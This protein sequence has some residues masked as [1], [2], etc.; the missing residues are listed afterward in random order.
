MLFSVSGLRCSFADEVP[1]KGDRHLVAVL[2][3]R[4]DGDAEM[5]KYVSDDVGRNVRLGGLKLR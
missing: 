5:A 3:L 1:P 4:R 2:S